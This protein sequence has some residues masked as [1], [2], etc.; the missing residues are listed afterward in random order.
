MKRRDFIM[1]G[2]AGALAAGLAGCGAKPSPYEI[3]KIGRAHV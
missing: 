2:T 1:Q 3:R